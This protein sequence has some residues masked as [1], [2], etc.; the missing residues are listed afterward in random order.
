MNLYT[1]VLYF[2]VY[3]LMSI[4]F[5]CEK[6]K[7]MQHFNLSFE[8]VNSKVSNSMSKIYTILEKY[9]ILI[10]KLLFETF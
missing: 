4:F 7:R 1:D 5:M 9:V 6:K 10:I 3:D 8:N 2:W